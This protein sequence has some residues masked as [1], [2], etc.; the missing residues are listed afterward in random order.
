VEIVLRDYREIKGPTTGSSP[1]RCSR[2]WVTNTSRSSSS[3]ATGSSSPAASWPAIHCHPGPPLRELPQGPRLDPQAHLPGG[4]LPSLAV[5]MKA[6]ANKT[7]L[8]VQSVENIGPDYARTLRD[9]RA[10]FLAGSTGG[11]PGLRPHLPAQVGLLPC[12]VRGLLRHGLPGRSAD[13]DGEVGNRVLGFRGQGPGSRI[14]NNGNRVFLPDP[15]PCTL[16]PIPERGEHAMKHTL[17]IGMLLAT[18]IALWGCTGGK[19]MTL[20]NY[21]KELAATDPAKTAL[22]K[23]AL[24]RKSQA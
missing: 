1:S 22:V 7:C 6:L 11:R 12:G 23:P 20:E 15:V 9:W 3:A 18:M 4:E 8:N 14:K 17:C 21:N 13:G 2:P 16:Y 24:P 19:P 10:R 5:V